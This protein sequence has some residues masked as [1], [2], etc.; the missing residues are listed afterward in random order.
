MTMEVKSLGLIETVGMTA[1][2]EAADTAVKAANVK[3]VGFELTKGD[4]MVTVKVQGDVGAVKAAVDAAGMSAAKVG[5]VVSTYVIPRPALSTGIMVDNTNTAGCRDIGPED[6]MYGADNKSKAEIQ[7]IDNTVRREETEST[8]S[9]SE[10][11]DNSAGDG[12]ETAEEKTETEKPK[13]R[14]MKKS[15]RKLSK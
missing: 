14:P 12:S 5:T 10:T 6:V 2:V 11:A 8:G 15:N 9:G 3:L 1:A 13:P 7:D 4:G